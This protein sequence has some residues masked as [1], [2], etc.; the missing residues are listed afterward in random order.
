MRGLYL[1][2]WRYGPDTDR[3]VSEALARDYWTA[4]QWQA[5]Q[6]E[7]LAFVLDRAATR[8]PYY[9]D[10]WEERRRRG[11]D[12]SWEYLENWPILGKEPLREHPRAFVADDCA[13]DKMFHE[14]TSGTTGK[15]LD[16]WWSKKMTQEWYA[17]FEARWRRW[18]GVSRRDR[19]A[20]LGGQLVAPV[21]VRKPPFWVYNA[22]MRQL[23]MSSF[24]LAPDLIPNYL[25]ALVRYR[26]KYLWGYSSSLHALAQ[27]AL[28]LGR[29]DIRMAVVLTNAEPVFDYQRQDIE[30]AFGCPLRETYGMSE[31]VLA[32]AECDHGSMHLWPEAGVAEV[33]DENGAVPDGTSGDLICTGLLNSDMP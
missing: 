3:L 31:A 33:V 15:S 13:P 7:R 22:A 27:E 11:D 23:Y 28:R 32:A 20:I 26:I 24:H 30:E 9:R 5:W 18:N 2:M 10:H 4:E 21:E 16:L 12:S 8:V 25:D 17:L 6:E 19:W 29:R 1:S 14:H